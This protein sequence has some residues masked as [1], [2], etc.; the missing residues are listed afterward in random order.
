MDNQKTAKNSP[1]KVKLEIEKKYYWCTCGLS[2]K[3]PFC[4][5]THKAKGEFR[6]CILTFLNKKNIFCAIVKKLKIHRFVTGPT[7]KY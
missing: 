1:E 3:Q 2:T 5:G 4:D 6:P 7:N